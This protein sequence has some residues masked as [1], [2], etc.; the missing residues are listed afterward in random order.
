MMTAKW[1]F[2]NNAA[3]DVGCSHP[4]C[5]MSTFDTVDRNI[6]N[7]VFAMTHLF[8][9]GGFVPEPTSLLHPEMILR[10]LRASLTN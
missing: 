4:F 3:E 7:T 2:C 10:A 8:E 6:H 9:P 1:T 5:T